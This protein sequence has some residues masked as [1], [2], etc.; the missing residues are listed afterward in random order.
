[1]AA[2]DTKVPGIGKIPKK[3]L[4]V[5]LGSAAVFVGWRYWQARGAGS[6]TPAVTADL[7][8][9]L[10]ASGVV[11]SGGGPGNTQYAGT[12]TDNTSPGT[13]RTNAEWTAAAVDKLTNTGGWAASAVYASLGDFLGRRPL[14]DGE[15]QIVRAAIAAVG[16][17]PEGGPYEVISAPGAV[18]LAQVTGVHTTAVTRTSVDVAWTAVPGVQFYYVYVSGR[19]GDPI[20]SRDNKAS[21]GGLKP[22]TRYSISVAAAATGTGKI[23]PRSANLS[24]TTK[25]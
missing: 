17:P 5:G 12:V 1:M 9:P 24:V 21:V 4:W 13:I 11:G 14:T 3:W 10:E 19:G 18:T 15:Q 23:G 8:A 6:T 25:K 20:G 2:A 7:G 22:A 16:Q